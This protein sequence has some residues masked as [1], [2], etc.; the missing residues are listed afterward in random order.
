MKPAEILCAAAAWQPPDDGAPSAVTEGAQYQESVFRIIDVVLRRGEQS[1]AFD[2]ITARAVESLPYTMVGGVTVC[3]AQ[4]CAT[5][6]VL[7]TAIRIVTHI[8][9]SSA[10]K[11]ALG[12][13]FDTLTN[14]VSPWRNPGIIEGCFQAV[15]ALLSVPA[16]D[17]LTREGLIALFKHLRRPADPGNLAAVHAHL[18]AAAVFRRL[19]VTLA[20]LQSD[21]PSPNEAARLEKHLDLIFQQPTSSLIFS[22]FRKQMPS[23]RAKLKGAVSEL[24]IAGMAF[25]SLA[26]QSTRKAMKQWWDLELGER[27]LLTRTLALQLNAA[28]G[29]WRDIE[30]LPL[31]RRHYKRFSAVV[32]NMQEREELLWN[33]LTELPAEAS[34]SMDVEVQA[35]VEDAR[36]RSVREEDG[37][38]GYVLAMISPAMGG[39]IMDLVVREIDRK[40]R[41]S[42]SNN[43]PFDFASLLYEIVLRDPDER[44]FNHLLPRLSTESDRREATLFR[45]F[46]SAVRS[47]TVANSD[48]EPLLVVARH[49]LVETE[50]TT[51]PTLRSLAG[52]LGLFQRLVATE[53]GVWDVLVEGEIG[54]LGALFAAFDALAPRRGPLVA[55]CREQL[56]ELESEVE[57]YQRLPVE[58]FEGRAR[59]LEH[60]RDIADE[61]ISILRSQ[62]QL[63]VSERIFLTRVVHHLR[64]LFERTKRWYCEEPHRQW[65]AGASDKFWSCFLTDWREGRSYNSQ[66]RLPWALEQMWENVGS[67]PPPYRG[68]RQRFEQFFVRWMSSEIDA[69]ALARA[70]APRWPRWFREVFRVMTNLWSIALIIFLPCMFAAVMHMYGYH[71]F[72]GG[73]FFAVNS[74]FLAATFLAFVST[75]RRFF[76]QSQRQYRFRSMFPR[77]AGF[78]AAPM[79]LIVELEH[80][81][82]FPLEASTESLLLLLLVAFFAIQFTVTKA[83]TEDEDDDNAMPAVRVRR[84]RSIVAVA[85]AQSFAIA[86]LLSMI[87]AGRID[88][89]ADAQAGVAGSPYHHLPLLLGV[90]PREVVFDISSLLG[91]VGFVV[92]PALNIVFYPTIILTWTALGVLF[93]VVFEG[94]LKGAKVRGEHA[95]AQES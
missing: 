51:S 21:S 24:L 40:L 58:E 34:E 43:A 14:D 92:D 68:Q 3:N 73:G 25:D 48:V 54:G 75:G 89:P 8:R 46:I 36:W 42:R 87:F 18:A 7:R 67:E 52:M 45:D 19:L 82:R 47:V 69:A 20:T 5:V 86:L 84:V 72:E 27:M 23:P 56:V 93:G 55:D 71:G 90:L 33:I 66:A 85:L 12:P 59:T 88:L 44:L 65:K 60:A 11:D 15:P 83:V 35:F 50:D 17:D 26:L 41:R 94:F 74:A 63:H 57:F 16:H 64:L 39:R 62:E 53:E 70:L 37:L 31:L 81:Y 22:A 28:A 79:A 10:T 91:S 77:V 30:R 95:L 61:L 38:P 49:F 9:G 29:E 76:G 1:A 32:L 6:A 78:I 2:G 80:A 4:V 13:L